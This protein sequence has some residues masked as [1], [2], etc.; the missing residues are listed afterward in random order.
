[1]AN[2][3]KWYKIQAKSDDVAEISIFGDIG[4]WWFDSVSAADFKKDFDEIKGK[5]EINVLINSPGGDVF[6]GIAIHNIIATER[7]KVSVEV[8]GLAASAA[9]VIALAGSSL[10]IDAGGFFMIHNV[11]TFAMGDADNLR[12]QADDLDKI[13]GELVNIYEAHS[14]LSAEEIKGYMDAETWFTA[15][16]AIEAGFADESVEHEA[17]AASIAIDRRYAYKH[18]PERFGADAEGNRKPPDNIRDFEGFLRD[19]GFSRKQS[20][21]IAARGFEPDQGD[22]E[23]EIDQGD[24][25]PVKVEAETES[26]KDVAPD[27]FWGDMYQNL[28]DRRGL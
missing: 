14:D 7:E 6:D 16:E 20:E 2:A 27:G 12:K 13:S 28:L 10:K 15:A 1:V 23:P 9:S 5:K 18:V 24:P 26:P 8:L 21:T 22:P 3:K 4:G 19:A 11:W 25:E 17:A